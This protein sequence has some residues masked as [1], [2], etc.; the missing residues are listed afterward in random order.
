M[1]YYHVLIL[2]LEED[3]EM[4][5]TKGGRAGE[6]FILLL[7]FLILLFPKGNKQR[8]VGV[9][10]QWKVGNGFGRGVHVLD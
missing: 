1:S 10:I 7:P 5:G 9:I 4:A 2:K 8:S 3:E 6:I